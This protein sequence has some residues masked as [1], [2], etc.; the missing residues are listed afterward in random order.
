MNVPNVSVPC[1]AGYYIPSR[2]LDTCLPC[3]LGTYQNEQGQT[4][5]KSCLE[6]S[7]T[8][9]VGSDH[10]VMCNARVTEINV[11]TT[12]QVEGFNQ[13]AAEEEVGEDEAD[14]IL[15]AVL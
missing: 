13:Y 10:P 7:T 3:P 4:S 6:G 9:T 15:E 11:N 5:C 12:A 8:L 1:D 2:E 14:G